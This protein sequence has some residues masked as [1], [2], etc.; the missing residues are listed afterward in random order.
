M[1]YPKL[2]A[3]VCHDWQMKLSKRNSARLRRFG[4]VGSLLGL[5]L[6]GAFRF[7]LVYSLIALICLGMLLYRIEAQRDDREEERESSFR[8]R[9]SVL[10][11][12]AG[13]V[14]S[15]DQWS[16]TDG[17]KILKTRDDLLLSLTSPMRVAGNFL[18][19]ERII[20]LK[21]H[22]TPEEFRSEVNSWYQDARNRQP[23]RRHA[24]VTMNNSNA[25][26]FA[27]QLQG[28][29]SPRDIQLAL[30]FPHGTEIWSEKAGEDDLEVGLQSPMPFNR[31]T[32][33]STFTPNLVG[34]L[35][36]RHFQAD[37]KS[38]VEIVA[39]DTGTTVTQTFTNVYVGAVCVTHPIFISSTAPIENLNV[40]WRLSSAALR[41][42][43]T[44]EI[45]LPVVSRI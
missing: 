34:S 2:D 15:T 1:R 31:R 39:S 36:P 7:E 23:K 19:L 20:A 38:A 14:V 22:R 10:V 24:Y 41:G 43:C 32:I 42:T 9:G 4:R 28:D 26:T 3:P 21:E 5:A 27:I 37:K 40:R 6:L 16:A 35:F 18:H 33:A 8:L 45:S 25:T 17:E 30:I 12:A 13:V 44:G 29:V 11:E